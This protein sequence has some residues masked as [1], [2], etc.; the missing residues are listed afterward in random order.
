MWGTGGGGGLKVVSGRLTGPASYDLGGSVADIST[1]FS[2]ECRGAR[3]SDITGEFDP[4]YVNAA[5]NA[6]ATGKILVRGTSWDDVALAHD[7]AWFDAAATTDNANVW[8]KPAN[9]ECVGIRITI[10]TQFAA[11]AATNL[12]VTVGDAGDVNGL[13]A[14]TI[15]LIDDVA[16]TTDV[17][18]GAEIGDWSN[19]FATGTAQ[20]LLYATSVAG[21]LD[22]TT[23]GLATLR[24]Y[25]TPPDNLTGALGKATMPEVHSGQVLSGSTFEF[26]AWGTDA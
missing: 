25:F 6:P 5:A 24:A 17:T 18:W 10:N 3:V 2:D 11:P 9:S 4:Y 7:G 8:L 22:T 20:F 21:N 13:F 16:G 1:L 15:D 12:T 26:L 19:A 14:G 23:A